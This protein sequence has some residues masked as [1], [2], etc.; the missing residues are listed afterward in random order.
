MSRRHV[1][2]RWRLR[3]E[4]GRFVKSTFGMRGR[5]VGAF[6][7]TC[8]CCLLLV[9]SAGHRRSPESYRSNLR[10]HTGACSEVPAQN[11]VNI[12]GVI[13]FIASD[14]VFI[15]IRLI[16]GASEV[17]GS[18]RIVSNSTKPC[19]IQFPARKLIGGSSQPDLHNWIAA[20]LISVGG[21]SQPDQGRSVGH[22]SLPSQSDLQKPSKG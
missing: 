16:S 20:I 22:D 9:F 14:C 10:F 2:P 6:F 11:S 17:T 12:L 19:A 18:I 8:V 4:P 1:G 5:A 13:C 7:N 15:A 21:P 3:Y